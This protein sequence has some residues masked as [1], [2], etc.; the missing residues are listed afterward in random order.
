ME[1][2]LQATEDEIIRVVGDDSTYSFRLSGVHISFEDEE[3]ELS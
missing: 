2:E 1:L 3:Q